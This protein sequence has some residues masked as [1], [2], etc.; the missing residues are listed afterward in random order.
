[1]KCPVSGFAV[2]AVKTGDAVRGGT[3]GTESS[4]THC[5]EGNGFEVS[6]P[7]Q[8]TGTVAEATKVRLETV[9]YLPGTDRRYG[10]GGILSM[11]CRDAP[12]ER[13]AQI[14]RRPG[15]E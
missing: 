7:R 10:A 3:Q 2:I 13:P 9:A 12:A 5:W 11:E 6:V 8:E 4:Q 14:P 1:M 15:P